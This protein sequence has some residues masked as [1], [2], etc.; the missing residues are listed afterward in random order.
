MTYENAACIGK[1]PLTKEQATNVALRMRRAYDKPVQPYRCKACKQWHVGRP[2][3]R[4][5]KQKTPDR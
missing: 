4:K 2:V 1:D 3:R 5:P